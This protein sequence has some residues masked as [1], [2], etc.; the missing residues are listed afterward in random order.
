MSN[1][2]TNISEELKQQKL[3]HAFSKSKSTTEIASL[4]GVSNRVVECVLKS[5][6]ISLAANDGDVD[7]FLEL[8]DQFGLAGQSAFAFEK[9]LLPS[10]EDELIAAGVDNARASASRQ[11]VLDELGADWSPGDLRDLASSLLRLADSV[12]QSWASDHM[13]SR[14]SWPSKAAAIERNSL[15]LAKKASMLLALNKRREDHIPSEFL[16]EP[17]WNMLLELF[18]QFAG[19]ARISSKSLCIASGS[20]STTAL[21]T[22]DRLETARLV[23]RSPSPN[24]GRVT[25]VSLTRKGVLAVGRFLETVPD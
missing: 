18:C 10:T 7:D 16:G 5:A 20:P 17:A 3:F 13:T 9:P 24:D 14:F 21:R 22:I 4:A 19:G 1:S 2:K 12:D 23:E 15:R 6:R 8:I 25:F 11:R